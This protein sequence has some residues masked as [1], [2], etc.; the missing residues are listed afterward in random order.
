MLQLLGCH[1]VR[2][3]LG[4]ALGALLVALLVVAAAVVVACGGAQPKT[5]AA[6]SQ[7]SRPAGDPS[8]DPRAQIEV[9][10]QQIADELARAQLPRASA[11]CTGAACAQAMSQPFATPTTEDP[12]CH[13]A[14]SP[15]CSD[16]CTLSSS[17]CKNQEKICELARQLAAD[18]WA[19]GK[20][21]TARASCRTAHEHC[22]SCTG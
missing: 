19:A 8:A 9:L 6:P 2:T 11:T 15:R 10:D 22:C 17:I 1:A 16:A 12:Q 5:V 20:C 14:S 21:E 13:P 3:V 18:D 7:Q 4:V